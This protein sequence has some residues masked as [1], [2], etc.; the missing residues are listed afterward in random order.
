[1]FYQTHR[2][3]KTTKGFTLIEMMVAVSIFVIVAFIISSALLSMSLAYKKA[4]TMRLLMD[5]LNF[6]LKDMS[7]NISEGKN[8]TCSDGNLVAGCQSF[9]F[10][11]L[12]EWSSGGSAYKCY[13]VYDGKIKECDSSCAS[14]IDLSSPGITISSLKFTG[15]ETIPGYRSRILIELAGE[16]KDGKAT[17]QFNIST[18]VSQRNSQ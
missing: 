2:Q 3:F 14:C 16:A 8:F 5:N 17:S 12:A 6:A 18:I 11:P 4:Q 15:L 13:K 9:K 7:F 1:M 10:I